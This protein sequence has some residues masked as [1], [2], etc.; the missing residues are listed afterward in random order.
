MLTFHDGW[1]E[2]RHEE[3]AAKM[4]A[5]NIIDEI[6]Q[7][8]DALDATMDDSTAAWTEA[9]KTRLC[10]IGKRHEYWVYT[11]GITMADGGE[12]LYDVTWLDYD[13]DLLTSAVLVAECEWNSGLDYIDEDFQKL[14]IASA[15]VRLMIFDGGDAAGASRV[16]NHLAGQVAAFRRTRDEEEWLLAAWVSDENDQ[17]WSFRWFKIERGEPVLLPPL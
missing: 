10:E 13:G 12:W 14:L 11:A 7:G 17:G 6:R 1:E 16:A 9:V 3:K 15:G 4:D 5:E 2:A 8:L